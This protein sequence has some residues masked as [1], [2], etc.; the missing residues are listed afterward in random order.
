MR[1]GSNGRPRPRGGG[2]LSQQ[3]L[4]LG[5]R[6]FRREQPQEHLAQHL[7]PRGAGMLSRGARQR[8]RAGRAGERLG[9][10]SA[11]DPA[12]TW[13]CKYAVIAASKCR[14]LR[15]RQERSRA[16]RVGADTNGR[17]RR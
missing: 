17:W 11:H 15:S 12:A 9:T 6:P 2:A 1:V 8:L 13:L 14:R 7:P 4:K 3:Q 16:A 10:G 5:M